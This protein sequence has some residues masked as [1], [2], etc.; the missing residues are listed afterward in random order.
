MQK[1]IAKYPDQQARWAK[2]VEGTMT[3][4]SLSTQQNAKVMR[5]MELLQRGMR[6]ELERLEDG[7]GS[8]DLV[9]VK[10]VQLDVTSW[11]NEE[12]LMALLKELW[13]SQKRASGL[14]DDMIEMTLNVMDDE[15]IL[16][17]VEAALPEE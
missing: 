15:S 4:A 11:N 14:T 2:P 5:M 12:K 17:D 8:G 3:G 9:T 1:I 13:V 7:N 10:L 6:K 16:L